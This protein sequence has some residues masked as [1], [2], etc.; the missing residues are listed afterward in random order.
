MRLLRGFLVLIFLGLGF[1]ALAEEVILSYDQQVF[2]QTDGALEVV[3]SITVRAEGNQIRR[4][5]LRDFPTHYRDKGRTYSTTF[6]VHSVTMDGGPV[7]WTTEGLSNGTRIRIG[8]AQTFLNPGEY[9]YTIK[10]RTDRQLF[11]G[12]GFDELYWNVTGN[13]WDFAILSAS[14]TVHIPEG[15]V[16]DQARAYTGYQGETGG[17]AI[18][19]HDNERQITFTTTRRLNPKEGLTLVVTWPEGFVA[20]PTSE[21]IAA[22]FL[23]DNLAQIIAYAGFLMVLGYFYLAWRQVGKDPDGGAIY[24]SYGPPKGVSPGA[25]SYVEK[26]GYRQRAFTGAI[27]NMA[28]KGYLTITEKGKSKYLLSK[29]GKKVPLAPGEAAIADKL[30]GPWSNEIE[31]KHTNHTEFRSAMKAQENVLEK[32]H[33]NV[34]FI[35]NQKHF[36]IG[37]GISLVVVILAVLAS[38]NKG[39]VGIPITVG[40]VFFYALIIFALRKKVA[41]FRTSGSVGRKIGILFLFIFLGTHF[42]GLAGSLVM[43]NFFIIVPFV[44]IIALNILFYNL[45]EKPTLEGRQLLDEIVGFKLYLSVAEKDRLEFHTG[46]ITP[47][48]FEKFLPY[49]IA[50]G[51]E[52]K[53][54][55]AFERS[56]VMAG[57]DPG[58]YTP[59]WYHGHGFRSFSRNDGFAAGFGSAFAGAISSASTA[60][61]SS[62]SGGG[63]FSG[64][65]SFPISSRRPSAG[66]FNGRPSPPR[67]HRMISAMM[68]TASSSGVNA[69]MFSPTGA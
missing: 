23:I 21:E 31:T 50:L 58:I 34:H 55:K 9:T 26:R 52:N 51:V 54:G 68:L 32:N 53:W 40:F 56:M 33:E 6:D 36:W 63:G 27:V 3:E 66:I 13:G 20:R 43:M 7:N 19:N 17:G 2:V 45:L 24:A 62:G 42:M 61:S 38:L 18:V 11:F 15:A 8:S 69:P 47:E 64:G 1:P 14:A 67:R 37:A 22:N 35:R 65:G 48:V 28:V 41:V 29:T 49:A 46:T 16:V 60:P 59:I 25:I 10:Y 30:F 44:L 57:E 12:E 39:G 5:I 4:G